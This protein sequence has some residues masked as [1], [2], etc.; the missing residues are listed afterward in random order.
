MT[1]TK[2]AQDKLVVDHLGSTYRFATVFWKSHRDLEL[3]DCKSEAMFASILAA[4]KFDPG[5]GKQFSTFLFLVIKRRLLNLARN[6]RT[7][8]RN[9]GVDTEAV[10]SAMFDEDDAESRC[11]EARFQE[12][13]N[14]R[15]PNLNR[16]LMGHSFADIGRAEGV[17]RSTI[18]RRA[19]KETKDLNELM[20]VDATLEMG[21]VNNLETLGV[22]RNDTETHR[23]ALVG[24]GKH[25]VLA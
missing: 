16:F 2:R 6:T 12:R 3:D 5:L 15:A 18:Y 8:R 19:V 10:E 13:L 20:G 25:P 7:R 17:N 4:Q 24:R 23:P 22:S 1:L 21:D 9:V 11:D 14:D